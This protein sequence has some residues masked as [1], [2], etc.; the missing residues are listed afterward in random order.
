MAPI[1]EE[2]AQSL[3]DTVNRL[4]ARLQQL[5]ARIDGKDSSSSPSDSVRMIL[6]GPP[7]AGK[8]NLTAIIAPRAQ[9]LMLMAYQLQARERKRRG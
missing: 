4:E 2:M 6:M 1:T 8:H 5:E 7:G 9:V 3:L